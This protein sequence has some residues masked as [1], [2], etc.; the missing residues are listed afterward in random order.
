[1]SAFAVPPIPPPSADPRDMS[2]HF[3]TPIP[4]EMQSQFDAWVQHQIRTTGRDPRNDRYDYDVN[5]YWIATRGATDERG[6]GTDQFKKPNHPTFS[7]ESQYH[8]QFGGGGQW[9][10]S[11]SPQTYYQPSALNL[12]NYQRPELQQYFRQTEPEVMLLGAPPTP[13]EIGEKAMRKVR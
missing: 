12:M 13:R 3:N 11:G 4:P 8:P 10:Q 6:H 5:G 1:M 9:M 7:N 2:G